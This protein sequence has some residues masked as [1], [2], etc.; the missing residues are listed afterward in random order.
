MEVLLPHEEGHA[1]GHQSQEQQGA[2]GDPVGLALE[3]EAADPGRG[4]SREEDDAQ[5]EAAEQPA[6]DE[7]TLKRFVVQ[8]TPAVAPHAVASKTLPTPVRPYSISTAIAGCLTVREGRVAM[9]SGT[10]APPV[11][12]E[13][14]A[15]VPTQYNH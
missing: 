3:T 11:R 8:I 2:D 4:D 7:Q 1:R 14:I 10:L 13:V 6:L 5:H 15:Y 9:T 12:V